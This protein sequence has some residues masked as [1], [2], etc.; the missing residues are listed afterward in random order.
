MIRCS[1]K[2]V[3]L[4]IKRNLSDEFDVAEKGQL[5]QR[6]QIESEVKNSWPTETQGVEE[7]ELLEILLEGD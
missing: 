7:S 2:S 4:E 5:D 1:D 6:H 3:I